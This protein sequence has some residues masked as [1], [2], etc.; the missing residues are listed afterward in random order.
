ESDSGEPAVDGPAGEL[1]AA[2]ELEL[3]EDGGDVGLHRLDRDLQ[4]AGDLLVGVAPGDVAEDLALAGGELVELG[5]GGGDVLVAGECVQDEAGEAG[6]EDGVAVGDTGD[7]VGQLRAR[8]GLG[9]VAARA[10]P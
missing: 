4:A 7:G 2:G 6:R 8:D 3:P 1:V 5:V 10:G 9:D